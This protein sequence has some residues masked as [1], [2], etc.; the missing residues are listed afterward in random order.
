MPNEPTVFEQYFLELVNRARANPL[1]EAGRYGDDLNAGLAPGTLT[2][3]PKQPLAFDLNL[4]KAAR[5]H[6]D[7][8]LQTDVFSHTGIGGSTAG[9]RMEM[10]GYAFDQPY[11][12]AENIVW[13]GSTGAIDLLASVIAEHE[14]LFQSP[15]HRINL[16]NPV[17][18]QAGIGLS[19]GIFSAQGTA[20]NALMGT[21]NFTATARGPYLTG[22]VMDDHNSNGFYDIGEGIGNVSILATG[23][24]GSFATTSWGAGGYTLELPVGVYDVTFSKADIQQSAVVSIGADNVKFDADFSTGTVLPPDAP[25][26]VYRFYNPDTGAHFYTADVVE[27]EIVRASMPDFQYEGAAFQAQGDTE[28]YRFYNPQTGAHFYTMSIEERDQVIETLPVFQFEGVSYM[29][30]QTQAPDLVP[31]HR[32]YNAQTGAHFYTANGDEQ[33]Y[34]AENVPVFAYEGVSYWVGIA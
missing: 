20:F 11:V 32:F 17:L 33:E 24:A 29:A 23:Q 6:S 19:E 1:A 4:I 13:Q 28:V 2:A 31:L 27:R 25:G 21:Q 12:W 16:L 5:L 8:M 9:E 30:S 7:W 22:V 18:E 26:T 10:A 14:A 34:V 3:A 15:G